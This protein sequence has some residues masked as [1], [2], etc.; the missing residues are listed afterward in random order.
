MCNMQIYVHVNIWANKKYN[1]FP[2]FNKFVGTIFLSL[3]STR[4]V[5]GDFIMSFIGCAYLWEESNSMGKHNRG[6]ILTK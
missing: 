5:S 2:V 3:E 4:F 1:V 6:G